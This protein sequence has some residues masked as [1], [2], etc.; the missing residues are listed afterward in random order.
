MLS[1]P[2]DVFDSGRM[3]CFADPEGAVF[4]VWQARNQHRGAQV[5][6][7]HGSVNFNGLHTRDLEGAKAF[8]GAVF[9][10]E[11]LA[12]ACGWTLPGYGDHLEELNPGTRERTGEMGGPAASRRSSRPRPR[13]PATRRRT[14]T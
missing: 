4:G 12:W 3:A 11:A 5:V 13:R 10:W 7:E 9:G 8:Y 6:N 2:I 14:G 1:E